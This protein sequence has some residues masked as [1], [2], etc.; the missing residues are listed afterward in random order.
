MQDNSQLFLTDPRICLIWQ[1]EI[2]MGLV[3]WQVEIDFG[4]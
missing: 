4:L 3:I 1:V 2:G